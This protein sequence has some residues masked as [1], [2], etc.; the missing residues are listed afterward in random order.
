[1]NGPAGLVAAVVQAR[2][3]SS[4]LPGKILL[5]LAGKPMLY[6][7]LERVKR[8]TGVNRVVLA[9]AEGRADDAVI[10][11]VAGLDVLVVRGSEQ[12]VL[13]RTAKAAREAGADTV[14]RITSDCP[15]VDPGVSASILQAYVDGLKN[16]VQYART[17]I[18]H[19][20]P[21]GFD[22][23]VF[24]SA[25]LYESDEKSATPMSVNM[26]RPISGAAQKSF[27]RSRLLVIRIAAT[28]GSWSIP[29]MITGSRARYMNRSFHPTR[30]LGIRT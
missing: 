19:G 21:L 4:R 29:R 17:A 24:A 12:D 9:L 20:Y 7:M 11:A 18:E 30:S 5:P 27:A 6:R 22:T 15:L 23:E 3:T 13:A 14:M 26:R 2:M 16:G 28:G 25:C 10:D 8:I 1:M